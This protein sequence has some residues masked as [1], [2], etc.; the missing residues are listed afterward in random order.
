MNKQPLPTRQR[1]LTTFDCRFPPYIDSK[2][3]KSPPVPGWGEVGHYFDRCIRE[4]CSLDINVHN[5]A[6]A[7]IINVRYMCRLRDFVK[8]CGC[9]KS[10]H[11]RQSAKENPVRAVKWRVIDLTLHYFSFPECTSSRQNH[12]FVQG[13]TLN[14]R[15]GAFAWVTNAF[16]DLV[17][18]LKRR[19]KVQTTAVYMQ[20]AQETWRRTY[21]RL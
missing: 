9:S 17:V 3:V 13:F 7:M 20:L 18:K 6:L 1:N 4:A 5:S 14:L 16:H 21:V 8:P 12:C 11:E 2:V 10:C 19:F 15:A